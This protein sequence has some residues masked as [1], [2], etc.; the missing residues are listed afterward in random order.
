MESKALMKSLDI[1]AV[2]LQESKLLVLRVQLSKILL[3]GCPI[4][5]GWSLFSGRQHHE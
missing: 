5:W 3:Q 1:H 4:E 2:L